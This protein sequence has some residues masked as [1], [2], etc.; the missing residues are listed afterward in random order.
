MLMVSGDQAAC[1][2]A[3]DLLGDGLTTVQVKQ[4]FGRFSARHK[5]PQVAR[6]L[7]ETGAREAL[8]DL[9][10]VPPYDPGKPCTIE[11]EMMVPD[12]TEPYRHRR[13]CEVTGPAT[14]VSRADDWWSAWSQFYF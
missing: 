7:I 5:V 13:G 6:R 8:S 12:L 11:V 3:S 4:S 2:E 9:S 10:A 1:E 14:V